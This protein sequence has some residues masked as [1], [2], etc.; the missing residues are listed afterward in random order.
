[1]NNGISCSKLVISER[2]IIVL[3]F[4]PPNRYIFDQK[5]GIF[6]RKFNFWSKM[7]NLT[8]NA[9]FSTKHALKWWILSRKKSRSSRSTS[10]SIMSSANESDDA[11]S[12]SRKILIHIEETFSLNFWLNFWN[13][14]LKIAWDAKPEKCW[15]TYYQSY[16]WNIHWKPILIVNR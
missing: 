15:P 6:E 12:L 2:K 11:H 1:M 7:V 3:V 9:T 5:R 14:Y 16:S 13:F 8:R 4:L 10:P